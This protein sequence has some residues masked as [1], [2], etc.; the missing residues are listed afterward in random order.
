MY[1]SKR[2]ENKTN[3]R[4]EWKFSYYVMCGYCMEWNRSLVPGRL[5]THQVKVHCK[6][7]ACMWCIQNMRCGKKKSA[8][9]TIICTGQIVFYCFFNFVHQSVPFL[10]W[11]ASNEH[12]T[13]ICLTC[14]KYKSN[15]HCLLLLFMKRHIITD[16]V[17]K[18]Y[19]CSSSSS[20]NNRP[21]LNS[22]HAF[23]QQ[24]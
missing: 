21:K 3:E 15:S 2:A 20:S 12:N 16:C 1:L 22:T 11:N 5:A 24:S 6:F 13:Q 10:G 23:V 9:P 18:S 7:D 14:L 17:S 19:L 8:R 4:T